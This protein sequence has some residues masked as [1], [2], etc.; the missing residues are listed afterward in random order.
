MPLIELASVRLHP[1]LSSSLPD[2]FTATWTRACGLATSA[3]NGVPFQLYQSL[4]PTSKDMYYLVGG[5]Q[6]GDDHIAF[7]STPD[8]VTLAKSIGEYMT[9]ELVR[10]VDG[11][12]N[13]L[14]QED[15]GKP[16]RLRVTTY[17]VP[18]SRIEDW[19]LKWN[20]SRHASAGAGGWDMSGAVQ[21]QH[22][23]FK[24]MGE[25]ANNVAAFGGKDESG[26]KTWVWVESSRKTSGDT[27]G[28][29]HPLEGFDDIQAEVFEMEYVLG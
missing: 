27:G 13:A 15:G 3:A 8:A 12:I 21:K 22:R 2:S 11:D 19:A 9:V 5:W 1:S 29:Q 16:K 6:S 18:E 28:S 4:T 14:S 25:A 20:N 26:T 23:A 10:H 7:L 17:K 24:Q